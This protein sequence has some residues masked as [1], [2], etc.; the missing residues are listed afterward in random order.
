MQM[1][2]KNITL[3]AALLV[4]SNI[5]MAAA[6]ASP[7][8]AESP[9]AK[10][11]ESAQSHQQPT[12]M[13]KQAPNDAHHYAPVYRQSYPGY[14]NNVGVTVESTTPLPF[15]PDAMP[16]ET[17]EIS[18]PLGGQGYNFSQGEQI[19]S[20]SQQRPTNQDNA[21]RSYMNSGAQKND[22][23]SADKANQS[24]LDRFNNSKP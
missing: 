23:W 17:A 10:R 8:S 18:S 6:V 19:Y 13:H 3:A 21:N 15:S 14:G 24:A 5:A 12:S 9:A 16:R 4:G 20:S 22:S 2:N 11:S 1:G 7:H